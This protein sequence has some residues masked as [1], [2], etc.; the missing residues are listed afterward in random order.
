MTECFRHFE[1]M[2]AG[3][4]IISEP[5]PDTPFYKDSPL[6]QIKDWNEGCKVVED[7]LNDESK[8]EEIHRKTLSWWKEKCSEQATAQYIIEN[9]EKLELN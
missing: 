4:V 1:A 5:L 9:I 7:L 8:L 6:I 3:C 2:R